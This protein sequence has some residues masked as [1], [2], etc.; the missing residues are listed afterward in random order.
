MTAPSVDIK[1]KINGYPT[2]YVVDKS[3]RISFVEIG[4]DEEKFEV[5]KTHIINLLNEN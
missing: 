2:M 3:G 4:Y 1:Y 5:F